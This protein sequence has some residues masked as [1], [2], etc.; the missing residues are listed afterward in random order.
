MN[1]PCPLPPL[2]G[3]ALIDDEAWPTGVQVALVG[4]GPGDAGLLT[5]RARARLRA[6]EVVLYDHLINPAIL[7]LAAQARLCCV[8]KRAG[9]HSVGQRQI[10]QLL[11][12]EA[13]AGRR[14]VRLKGGDPLLFGRGGEEM[15]ALA[16]AGL[17]YEVTPGVSA[18][19]GAAAMAH[20]PLT[21]R[22]HAQGCT[23]VTGHRRD[24]ASELAWAA[25]T[26]PGA[27]VVVYMGVRQAGA[28]AQALMQHGRAA[29]TPAA[30]IEAATTP[31][32]RVIRTR[33]DQLGAAVAEHDAHTPALLVIGPV[34]AV[35]DELMAA[36]ALSAADNTPRSDQCG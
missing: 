32:Q 17:R 11:I 2:A 12:D 4:A 29:D 10:E 18:A 36:V 8:G 6:A 15:Q 1:A 35:H 30:V 16:A 26:H 14:V 33:L 3:G 19:L 7:A 27:T 13:C 28:I 24:D 20:L 21:H 5:L 23:L 22:D 25:H 31:R 34:L 9:A